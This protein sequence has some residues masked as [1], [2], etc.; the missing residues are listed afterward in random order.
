MG[1]LPRMGVFGRGKENAAVYHP[2][3]QTCHQEE[4]QHKAV[5][6]LEEIQSAAP[7]DSRLRLI[8][9][10]SWLQNVIYYGIIGPRC[11][12]CHGFFNGFS[13]VAFLLKPS[14]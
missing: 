10:G 11:Q 5:T 4:S 14:M 9:S 8:V 6:Q 12:D 1:P 13:P 2:P 7:G 3:S